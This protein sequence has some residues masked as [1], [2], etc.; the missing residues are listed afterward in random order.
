MRAQFVVAHGF[1]G[2]GFVGMSGVTASDRSE[3]ERVGDMMFAEGDDG[4]DGV[5]ARALAGTLC[6][7]DGK[8]MSEVSRAGLFG[9]ARCSG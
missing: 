7:L 1:S 9:L 2:I 6:G 3:I 5:D 8:V 4:R